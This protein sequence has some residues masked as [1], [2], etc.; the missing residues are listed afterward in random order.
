MDK[1]VIT[2]R[3]DADDKHTIRRQG[4]I[5]KQVKKTDDIEV[6]DEVCM[7]HNNWRTCTKKGRIE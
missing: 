1:S 3:T 4:I 5:P 7:S 2:Y 6:K